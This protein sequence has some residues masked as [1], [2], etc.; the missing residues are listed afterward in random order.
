MARSKRSN[1]RAFEGL[2]EMAL[3]RLFFLAAALNNLIIG[4][5]MLIGADQA[6]VQI[7]VAGPAAG[8]MV[9]F[10]GLLIAV[11]GLAYALVA[12]RPLP[13]RNLVAVGALSKAGALVLASW[14]AIHNHIPQSTYLLAMGDLVFL[15]LFC[16]FLAQTRNAEGATP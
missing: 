16:I 10:A 3:W 6:A 7:G 12:Y 1:S 9:G 15:A 8:Y 13:N 14:H 2:K 5:L 4:T 11:F